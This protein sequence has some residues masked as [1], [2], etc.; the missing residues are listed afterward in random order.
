[1]ERDDVDLNAAGDRY[2]VFGGN[3]GKPSG[4]R[5]DRGGEVER[6]EP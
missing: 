6:L 5:R 3:V 4:A 1:V 2:V